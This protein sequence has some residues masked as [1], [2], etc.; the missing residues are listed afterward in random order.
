M[1]VYSLK[2]SLSLVHSQK[3]PEKGYLEK[4]TAIAAEQGIRSGR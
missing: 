3:V 4:G 1:M 2:I